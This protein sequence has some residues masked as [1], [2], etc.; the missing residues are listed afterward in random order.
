MALQAAAGARERLAATGER[1]IRDQMPQQHRDFFA[2]LPF[3]AVGVVD[4]SGQPWASLLTGPPGFARS[5]DPLRLQVDAEPPPGDPAGPLLADGAPV[6]LLGMEL[7]TRRRNRLNGRILRRSAGT[8][9][10][11]VDQSFGNCPKYIQARDV[12]FDAGA[13]GRR[14]VVD[15]A[16][17]AEAARAIVLDADT[18]F[19]ATAHPAAASRGDRSHGV[20]VSHRGGR[21]GF[22]HAADDGTLLVPDFAGNS[23]FNTLGNLLLEPRCGLLFVDFVRNRAAQLTASG[24]VVQG[25]A[26]LKSFAGA[27]RLLRLTVTRSI[28]TDNAFPLRFGPPEPSPFLEGTGR[29]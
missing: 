29:W 9:E 27:Q 11:A 8:L 15:E 20:D 18:F 16:S 13:A 7:P 23:Y 28:V 2:Q 24:T 25:G 5:P 14:G 19:I 26:E 4:G 10:V 3:L 6:G 22:V 12:S 17:L 21:P 1:F